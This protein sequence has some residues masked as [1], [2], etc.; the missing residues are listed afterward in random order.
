MYVPPSDIPPPPLLSLP[1]SHPSPAEAS[2]S[3]PLS[4]VLCP[5]PHQLRWNTTLDHRKH[6]SQTRCHPEPSPLPHAISCGSLGPIEIK[7]HRKP[8]CANPGQLLKLE[9][10]FAA[11]NSPTSACC[12][13]IARELGMDERQTQIL[14]QNRFVSLCVLHLHA[15]SPLTSL[16]LADAPRPSCNSSSRPA[17]LKS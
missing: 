12:R 3:S 8:S 5:L 4:S 14:F 2:V 15:L 11:D 17:Q 10:C 6:A 7:Q 16:H 1:A 9:E 13:D